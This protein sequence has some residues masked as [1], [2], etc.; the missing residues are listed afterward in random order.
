MS[1]RHC[2]NMSLSYLKVRLKHDHEIF[3]YIFN[4]DSNVEDKRQVV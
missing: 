1:S 3:F 2:H 4:T